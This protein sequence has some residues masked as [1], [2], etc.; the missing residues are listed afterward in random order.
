MPAQLCAFQQRLQHFRRESPGLRLASG[1]VE[2]LLH[3]TR[4][5]ADKFAK[6]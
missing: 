3:R 2:D 6:P 5:T 4:F 1:L